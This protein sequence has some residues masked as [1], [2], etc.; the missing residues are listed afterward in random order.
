MSIEEIEVFEV[1]GVV[2]PRV[3]LVEIVAVVELRSCLENRRSCGAASILT[4]RPLMGA[5]QP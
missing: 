2:L 3:A 4:I 5:D 1:V